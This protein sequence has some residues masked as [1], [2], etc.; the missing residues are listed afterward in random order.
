MP[1][2]DL[3]E[4]CDCSLVRSIALESERL[5]ESVNAAKRVSR[6]FAALVQVRETKEHQFSIDLRQMEAPHIHPGLALEF[7]E[8]CGWK[9]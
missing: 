9:R 1:A 3:T 2:I 6:R 4:I 7:M 5:L 8:L